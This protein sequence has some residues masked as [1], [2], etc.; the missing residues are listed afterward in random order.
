LLFLSFPFEPFLFCHSFHV[1]EFSFSSSYIVA[2]VVRAKARIPIWNFFQLHFF[3]LTVIISF[4]RLISILNSQ[5]T[6]DITNSICLLIFKNEL[7]DLKSFFTCLSTYFE[8]SK[9][10]IT[11]NMSSKTF[12][13]LQYKR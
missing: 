7:Q 12:I 6:N 10:Y 4:S 8:I 9:T 2:Y 1:E 13:C 3:S 5:V 11:I